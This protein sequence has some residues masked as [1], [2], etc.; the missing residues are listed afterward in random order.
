MPCGGRKKVSQYIII[1]LLYF[2]SFGIINPHPGCFENRT[3]LKPALG[4]ICSIAN[5][6]V[7]YEQTQSNRVSHFRDFVCS[8]FPKA[9]LFDFSFRLYAYFSILCVTNDLQTYIQFFLYNYI[10]VCFL[11]CYSVKWLKRQG[12][13]FEGYGGGMLQLLLMNTII[14]LPETM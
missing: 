2:I 5:Y 11:V 4:D 10:H 12:V 9:I 7:A 8:L 13:M 14:F 6:C 1:V 3:P